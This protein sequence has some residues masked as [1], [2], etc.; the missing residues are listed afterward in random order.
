MHLK[1]AVFFSL[2]TLFYE[3]NAQID[4]VLVCKASFKDSKFDN[5]HAGSAFLL[6]YEGKMYAC[7]AKHVLFFAKT[8]SMKTI[9]FGDELKSWEFVS[10]MNEKNKVLAGKLIN[11]STNEAITIP[12]KADWLVFEIQGDI[13]KD[14]IT[15]TLREKP[16]RE[17]EK[18]H[19]LGYPYN[20]AEPVNVVG[21]FIGLTQEGNLSLDIPKGTYGGCSGGPVLDAKGK[22]VGLVSMGYFNQKESKMVF[23]PS[24]TKHFQSIINE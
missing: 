9:S 20:T 14:I 17:G 4:S 12:P 2:I 11:E 7:T 18:V 16:L 23:E 6:R 13:P 8:D 22:L 1:I 5:P 15:Y 19:F 10:K 24:S 3:V 21:S